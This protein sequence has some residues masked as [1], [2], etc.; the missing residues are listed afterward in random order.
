MYKRQL[1]LN[2]VFPMVY[3]YNGQMIRMFSNQNLEFAASDRDPGERNPQYRSSKQIKDLD[4]YQPEIFKSMTEFRNKFRKKGDLKALE[5]TTEEQDTTKM[6]EIVFTTT[7]MP[8]SISNNQDFIRRILDLRKKNLLQR[9][10][11]KPVKRNSGFPMPEINDSVKTSTSIN[12]MK[13]SDNVS[14]TAFQSS[15]ETT[16]KTE[17]LQEITES[18]F[19]SFEFSTVESVT[20]STM[21][22]LSDNTIQNDDGTSLNAQEM[23]STLKVEQSEPVTVDYSYET[24]TIAT[25]LMTQTSVTDESTPSIDQ[26]THVPLETPN[27]DELYVSDAGIPNV[28]ATKT[29]AS[30]GQMSYFS[31]S[32]FDRFEDE[33]KMDQLTQHSFGRINLKYL[34]ADEKKVLRSIFRRKWHEIRKQLKDSEYT[35]N[36][37]NDPIL[38]EILN[39][40]K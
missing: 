32:N 17:H 28:T 2:G 15:T 5:N 38:M 13:Y 9:T 14:N 21:D 25:T 39:N 1:Q 8:M 26:T 34:S 10:T 27:N 11:S 4:P 20:M 24:T 31:D 22:S 33:Y 19:H 35:T 3:N 23:A 12:N 37:N 16:R 40:G 30:L 7:E 18:T 36:D 29:F 6:Q